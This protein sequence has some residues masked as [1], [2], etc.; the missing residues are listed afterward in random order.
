[1]TEGG[2]GSRTALIHLHHVY[3]KG[4]PFFVKD[5]VDGVLCFSFVFCLLIL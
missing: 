1:M 5:R 3:D 4:G 2:G